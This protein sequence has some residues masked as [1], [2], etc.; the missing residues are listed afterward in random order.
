MAH[1]TDD[2]L[3]TDPEKQPGV[4]L[5]VEAGARPIQLLEPYAADHDVHCAFCKQ[6]QLHKN[7]YLALLEDGRRALCGNVCAEEY[8]DKATV[9]SLDRKRDQLAGARIKRQQAAAIIGKA[10]DLL[11]I[12]D[13]DFAPNEWEAEA[14]MSSL[15]HF[16]PIAVREQIK[17]SDVQGVAYLG[18]PCRAFGDA[19]G[20]IACIVGKADGVTERQ[21]EKLMEKRVAVIERIE[22]GTHYLQ[23]AV[24]FFQPDN[25]QRFRVWMLANQN[26]HKV[27]G[28]NVTKRHLTITAQEGTDWKGDPWTKRYQLDLPE[29]EA[30]ELPAIMATLGW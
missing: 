21:A 29:I 26:L 6:K 24:A 25:L 1:H 3:I 28:I 9:S 14:A 20:G 5:E 18:Q 17:D 15:G 23:E 13:N 30:P 19:R 10:A 16:I 2:F 12:I 27:R 4:V 7:G 11:P 8:F 22:H